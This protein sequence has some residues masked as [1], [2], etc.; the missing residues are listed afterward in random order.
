MV[1]GYFIYRRDT[2]LQ[3]PRVL[4]SCIELSPPLLWTSLFL[5]LCSIFRYQL[6]S[7]IRAKEG[8]PL[9]G[10]QDRKIENMYTIP[11][12]REMV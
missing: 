10:E 12:N 11:S 1:I 7:F 6:S 3:D 4:Y 8:D 9:D 2:W 5:C